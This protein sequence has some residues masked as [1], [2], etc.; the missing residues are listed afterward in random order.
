[1]SYYII[2]GAL[3]Q[4]KLMEQGTFFPFRINEDHKYYCC[5]FFYLLEDFLN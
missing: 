2:I 5:E 3:L 4:Y 1:M